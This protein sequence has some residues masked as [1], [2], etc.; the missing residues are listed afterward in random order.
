MEEVSKL[1]KIIDKAQEIV[2]LNLSP[3][4]QLIQCVK[5]LLS[6]WSEDDLHIFARPLVY[7]MRGTTEF[8]QAPW[9]ELSEIDQVRLT[10]K[11]AQDAIVQFQKQHSQTISKLDG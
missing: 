4:E 7:Q 5:P 10:M 3:L 1:D 2:Y 9:D 6:N 8:K 11:I